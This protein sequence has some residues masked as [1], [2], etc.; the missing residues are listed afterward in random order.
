MPQIDVE[1]E[2][3]DRLDGL[4]VEDE[5]YDEIINELINI[6]KASEMTLFHAGDEY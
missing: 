2:T 6:Y 1:E 3:L 4:R 5:E